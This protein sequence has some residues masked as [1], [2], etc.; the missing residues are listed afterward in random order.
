MV[1]VFG[2]KFM[3]DTILSTLLKSLISMV[4]LVHHEISKQ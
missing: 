3:E 1:H 2:I 4:G